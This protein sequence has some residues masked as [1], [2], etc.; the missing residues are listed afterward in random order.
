MPGR[1]QCTVNGSG[2]PVILTLPVE[3]DGSLLDPSC[4]INLRYKTTCRLLACSLPIEEKTGTV[5]VPCGHAPFARWTAVCTYFSSLRR[6]M[7][8]DLRK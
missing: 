7:T 1:S 3:N 5:L 2:N 6:K 8:R 4:E